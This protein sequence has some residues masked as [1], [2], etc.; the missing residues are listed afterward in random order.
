[1]IKQILAISA[2]M[3]VMA[4]LCGA[5]GYKLGYSASEHE[6]TLTLRAQWASEDK[7]LQYAY[8][9]VDSCASDTCVEAWSELLGYNV[10]AK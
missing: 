7:R 10:I 1:M 5:V 9:Q 8:E 4:V 2:L 3:I 6:A